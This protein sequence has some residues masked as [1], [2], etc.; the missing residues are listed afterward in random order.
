MNKIISI[1]PLSPMQKG[2]LFETLYRPG[3][4]VNIVQIAIDLP[5]DIVISDLRD[6]CD[7]IIDR[8]AVLRTGFKWGGLDEPSQVVYEK[9]NL[10]YHYEDWRDFDE[11]YQERSF[12][13]Y[14]SEDRLS[15]FDLVK[16][17]LLRVALFRLDDNL[18]KFVWTYHH[19]LMGG[20][21]VLIV[22]KELFDIFEAIGSNQEIILEEPPS[23]R[24]YINWL[25]LQDLSG[26]KKYWQELLSGFQ[27]PTPFGFE[28]QQFQESFST[29]NQDTFT[30]RFSRDKTAELHSFAEQNQLTINTILQGIWAIIL[31]R[32]SGQEDVTFGVVKSNRYSLS[33][34]IQPHS[35]VGLLINTLPM[36]IPVYPNKRL[37]PFFRDIRAQWISLREYEHTP[38]M[39]IQAWSEITAGKPLF[40]SMV[41]FENQ[42]LNVVFRELGGLWSTRVVTWHQKANIPLIFS[43]ILDRGLHLDITYDTKR[44]DDEIICKMLG[45]IEVIFDS[46]LHNPNEK[47]SNL[48]LLTANEK[49]QILA[50]WN[51]TEADFNN[52]KCIHEI[53]EERAGFSPDNMAVVSGNQ[54]VTYRELNERANQIAQFLHRIGVGP[55]VIVGVCLDRSIEFISTILGI[56]KAGGAYLPIDPE[57][58]S[59]RIEFLLTDSAAPILITQ[60]NIIQDLP[61]YVGQ[62]IYLDHQ[63]IGTSLENDF[64][65]TIALSPGNLAYVIY[66][67]GS[68]GKPKGVQVTHLALV[69]HVLAIQHEFDRGSGDRIFQM[70]SFGFDFATGEIFQALGSGGTLVLRN[71]DSLSTVTEFLE[72]LQSFEITF[73]ALPTSVLHWLIDGTIQENLTLPSSIKTIFFGGEKVNPDKIKS[74]HHNFG[75]DVE[76]AN[77]YGP[78]EAAIVATNYFIPNDFQSENGRSEIPIGKPLSNCS[79]YILDDSQ[80]LL[81]VGVVGEIYISGSGLA[82]SY[83]NLP[84]LTAEKFIPNPYAE[85]PGSRMYRTG[86]MAKL[87]DNGN[88][89]FVG[90]LDQQVKYRGHR[91]ELGEIERVLQNHA[92]IRKAA[93][94]VTRRESGVEDLSA[95]IVAKQGIIKDIGTI[96]GYLKRH[97]PIYMVPTK[98][99]FLD[100]LPLSTNDKLDRPL[101]KSMVPERLE[102]PNSYS[103][104]VTFTEKIITKIWERLLGADQIGVD[105]NFF[106]LGGHSLIAAQI[107][108]ETKN[109]FTVEIDLK[110]LFEYPT[111]RGFAAQVEGLTQKDSMPI[112]P[113]NGSDRIPLSFAQQRLWFLD[114]YEDAFAA[115]NVPV[116]FRIMG[117]L[118]QGALEKSLTEIINRHEALRTTFYVKD[119]QPV[120][121]ISPEF[122]FNLSII[123]LQNLNDAKKEVEARRIIEQDAQKPFDLSESVLRSHLIRM[124]EEDSI[125]ALNIHHIATDGWSQNIIFKELTAL[126]KGFTEGYEPQLPD[127]LSQ[128]ADYSIWQREWL[129]GEILKEQL[130]YWRDQLE[131]V[132]PINLPTDKPYPTTQ[133]FSGAFVEFEISGELTTIIKRIC[134]ENGVTLF[135]GLLA[136]FNVFLSRYSGQLD[137]CIGTPVANRNQAWIENLV[138][139]F[140]NMLVIRTDL[141][142]NPT[143]IQL[144]KRVFETTL[145]AYTYQDIPFERLVSEFA[146]ER[147]KGRHPFFQ[148]IFVMENDTGQKLQFEGAQ[149]EP[150]RIDLRSAK[151]DLGLILN[152][153][154]DSIGGMLNYNTDLFERSTI[155]QMVDH[156]LVLL[157]G[158][159]TNPDQ[160]ISEISILSESERRRI[161][162]E[163]NSTQFDYPHEKSTYELFEEQVNK[164]PLRDAVIFKDQCMSYQELNNLANIMAI[165][166]IGKGVKPDT[167][168]GISM[169]RSHEMMI[170]LLGILK[171]GGVYLPIDPNNPIDR[172][173]FM[174]N[175]SGASILLT[176][177]SLESN[178]QNLN[179]EIIAVDAVIGQSSQKN[180]PNPS[181]TIHPENLAYIIYTSG[182]TGEPKGVAIRHASLTNNLLF[183]ISNT[184]PD[185]DL[186]IPSLINLTFDASIKHLFTPLLKGGVVWLIP[187]EV[188]ANPQFLCNLLKGKQKVVINCVPSYWGSVL[189][190]LENDQT[191]ISPGVIVKIIIGAEKFEHQLIDRTYSLFPEIEIWNMYGPTETTMAASSSKLI[192]DSEIT[193]GKPIGN[194]QVYILDQKMNPLPQNIPGILYVGGIGLARGYINTP[195]L[196][197]E[198][199]VPNPFD[200]KSGSRLYNTGDLVNWKPDGN[201][202][203]IGRVDQQVKIR[204]YRIEVEEIEVLLNQLSNVKRAVVNPYFDSIS[205]NILIA[206][207]VGKTHEKPTVSSLREYIQK[208]LPVYMVPSFFVFIEKLPINQIGKIDRLAL[209]K[210]DKLRSE[211]SG[212]YLGPRNH[213]EIAISR[214]WCE[215]LELDQIG[216]LDNFFE[217]GGH[218]LLAAQVTY[219]IQDEFQLDINVK[220]IFD[221]PTIAGLAAQLKG[222]MRMKTIPIKSRNPGD[223][224]P[225]SFAQQRLW[226]L[227]QYEP[228]L[229]AYN[230]PNAFWIKGQLDVEAIEKSLAEIIN[231]HE[232]LRTQFEI[233]IDQPVQ[234]VVPAKKVPF[235]QIDLQQLAIDDRRKEARRLV[236]EDALKPFDLGVGVIRNTLIQ[237]GI[238]EYILI[239]NIHHIASDGWSQAII[240]REISSLYDGFTKGEVPKLPDLQ[241]QYA[242]YSVWQREWLK[243]DILE[244]QLN[245]WRNQLDGASVLNLPIDQP[246]LPSPTYNGAAIDFEISG[247]QTEKL[248]EFSRENRVTLFMTML[249]MF[250]VFL[251]RYSGQL[252]ISVGT[253]IANRHHHWI[254][255][256]VGFFINMLVIRTDLLGN[257]SFEELIHRVRETTLDAYTYQDL[258]FEKLVSELNLDRDISRHPLF[259]VIFSLDQ[260][261]SAQLDLDGLQVDPYGKEIKSAKYEL[262]LH[263][264]GKDGGLKGIFDYNTDLFDEPTIQSMADHFLVV[265][266]NIIKNPEQP[267]SLLPIMRE[268]E[269]E[270]IVIGWNDTR[271]EFPENKCIHEL[272]EDQ[273]IKTPE[274]NAVIFGNQT[275]NYKDLNRSANQVARYLRKK[276]VGPDV[277]VGICMEKSL[278]LIISLLGILKAGGAYVP[279]DPS[280]PIERLNLIIN[281]S[282]I[283]KIITQKHL[284]QKYKNLKVD[285]IYKDSRKYN[286]DEERIENPNVVVMPENL[287]YI[288]YTS[289]STG[290]PKGVAIQHRSLVDNLTWINSKVYE[291]GGILIPTLTN[292]AFDVF[293]EELF[294]P[295][296]KGDAVWLVSDEIRSNPYEIC[297]LINSKPQVGISTVPSY[298]SQVLDIIVAGQVEIRKG[299]LTH[300]FTGAEVVRKELIDRTF[301]LFPDIKIWNLYGPTETTVNAT[302]T[303]IKMDSHITIGKP[304]ANTQVFILDQ[305]MQP[306]PVGVPGILYIGGEGLARGYLNSPSLTAESFL[307]NPFGGKEGSRLY[308]SGDLAKWNSDGL[309]VFLGRQDQQVKIRGLR[310]ELGE[311]ESVINQIP[312]IKNAVVDVIGGF[313]ASKKLVAYIVP[314]EENIPTNKEL[315]EEI[316]SYLPEYMVPSFFAFIDA[317]PLTSSGKIDRKA[318]PN[319][320]L[321]DTEPEKPFSAPRT[322]MEEII[323]G[324]WEKVLDIDKVGVDEN[325]FELGGHSLLAAQVVNHIRRVFEVD[326]LIKTLFEAPTINELGERIA[327]LSDPEIPHISPASRGDSLPL[328]FAQQRLW[329]LDQYEHELSAYNIPSGYR[330]KGHLDEKSLEMSLIEIIRRHE[331][332]RTTFKTIGDKPVQ[333]I[334]PNLSLPMTM[335]DLRQF[336]NKEKEAEIHRLVEADTHQA[337]DLSQNVMRILLFKLDFEDHIL[338]INIHHIASDGWSQGILIREL[339]TLYNAF[340]NGTRPTLPEMRFQYADYSIWQRGWLQGK[341][342]EKQRNYWRD[343]LSG[344]IVLDLPTDQPHPPAQS[345]EGASVNFNIGQEQSEKLKEISRQ[346]RVTLFMTLLSAFNILLA[347]FSGQ[348]D[349]CIGTPTANRNHL[350]IENMIGFFVNM[351]VIRT[352]LTGTIS[353]EELLNQIR[354][355]TLEAY[356]HQDIPFEK[357]VR[358]LD[359]ERDISRTPLF[360][361]I[362]SL[363]NEPE[364]PFDLDGLD[365]DRFH[366]DLKSAKFEM[367]LFLKVSN[368]GLT[369]AMNYNTDLFE[370]ST[371][372]RMID[373]FLVIIDGIVANPQQPVKDLPILRDTE[374]KRIVRNWNNTR[375]EYPREKCVHEIFEEQARG[376][377]DNIA[378]ENNNEKL[379]YRELNYRANQLANYLRDLGV[380]PEVMVGICME[381]SFNLVIGL[382][383]ILKAGSAYVPIDPEYPQKRT[384]LMLEETKA[385]VLVSD[386]RNKEENYQ[387]KGKTVYLAD[388]WDEISQIEVKNPV[389]EMKAENLAYVIFTSGSI[390]SPK[391]NLITHRGVVRLVKNPNYAKLTSNDVILQFANIA[392]DASTFEIW[393]ALLNG[394]I[395]VMPPPER[396]SLGEIGRIIQKHQVTTLWLTAGLFH[397]FVDT[398]L[399]KIKGVRQ[400]I[401]GG[402][403]ISVEHTNKAVKVLEHTQIINGYGP[404]ENTT[405][406]CCNSIQKDDVFEKT[407]P[408][409][410]PVSNTTVYILDKSLN[411]VPIGVAGELYAGGDGLSRG[412]LGDPKLTA[413]KFIPNPFN[414]T[415]GDRLY[416]TGDIVRYLEDGNIEF[417]GRQDHQV[418]VRG[419]RIELGEIEAVLNRLPCVKDVI[420]TAIKDPSG[421]KSLIAYIVPDNE[422]T[423]T[424]AIL[425]EQIRNH[426]PEYMMPKYFEFIEEFQLTPAGKIDR[427]RL[428]DPKTQ[429]NLQREAYIAPRTQMEIVLAGILQDVLDLDK[430]GVTDDFFDLGGHS[431]SATQVVARIED[432]FQVE[433]SLKKFFENPTIEGLSKII[434]SMKEVDQLFEE[435]KKSQDLER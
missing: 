424:I 197:A 163:W 92:D 398:T 202:E 399:E 274:K 206:Y 219:Q 131:G 175:D 180:I 190:F 363:D 276:G 159:V 139:F 78:T 51:N 109:E 84:G 26:A 52:G 418:K 79:V 19:I 296:L 164:T 245:Y 298:W 199:F 192:R 335:I 170:G 117:E 352:D 53:F 319:L 28:N 283:T 178:F 18:F 260:S 423:V 242:D 406:T 249:A 75:S 15:G 422:Q 356:S 81:P 124:K 201:L 7:Q 137:I 30:V 57:D 89:E 288:I 402:D 239:N 59:E 309:I 143:F 351:L 116:A 420:V 332:L 106:E 414:D 101:L 37:V 121:E 1:Y 326:I 391:G 36:R 91:V 345:Y 282:K 136:V 42:P 205:G 145:D 16:P 61:H 404:T 66:T 83:L 151:S 125:L 396:L 150:F 160:S 14:L 211:S 154:K 171:A 20:R 405:F 316:K 410:K 353:F 186:L 44:F 389:I 58:P 373:H 306:L 156:F 236:E 270:R 224:I 191:K 45:H 46:I 25:G 87:L 358:E 38:L 34:E 112:T 90:R 148:V 161:L 264:E 65:Q 305:N 210:P 32:Y 265:V 390:G 208:S 279:L 400:L 138:G 435:I 286:I 216:V 263:L 429:I 340:V 215:V 261:P 329:F 182:S 221:Y 314:G 107:N 324:I 209:P 359:L 153:T 86:D 23:Y 357:L 225:L 17:P 246:Y 130:N 367:G 333:V 289:G 408:I 195:A 275:L 379:T 132:G 322:Q 235:I 252:D 13:N 231:R 343:H 416:R 181:V 392:F 238:D 94:I 361:V 397:Q 234:V 303:I 331:V 336:T 407:V 64:T 409:G 259:Q 104:P 135:M 308:N 196:T 4:G 254:E 98:Y 421:G 432:N 425:H 342:L 328:S 301:S 63:E 142:G 247:E 237:L 157:N 334:N 11:R 133:T 257:P 395:L 430:V 387:F 241:N 173:K 327:E 73:I 103:E 290:K 213:R 126:Y 31:C 120:Q 187:E 294:A 55:E 40:E 281:D 203:F 56:L 12:E 388:D 194:T 96:R 110:L 68:T 419:F 2:M 200:K 24:N 177:Q 374:L 119:N 155:Q 428:P 146:T 412:Y 413:E 253:P 434:E 228:E 48:D 417:I 375:T 172:S 302:G 162:I 341:V 307:P 287:V 427:Q 167:V 232:A 108:F 360:Q 240:F 189:D 212:E 368:Q 248:R 318:L 330:I 277:P 21:A 69:N 49:H 204:G 355:T 346:K 77:G 220:L 426:L 271:T 218:S 344:I 311:I 300:L 33:D 365:V 183:A 258:P 123:D 168:V 230:M 377:P 226:F 386:A 376:K 371:I 74:F 149:V 62:I 6:A 184:L 165:Y 255:D 382:L 8:H 169:V 122:A 144:L 129:K 310:I 268:Q 82:R 366:I 166:L 47:I 267:V 140:I 60:E 102:S 67:S 381:R 179:A 362:F 262:G 401:A 222:L 272:F 348:E 347:R 385:K 50:E 369:G 354:E 312:W 250:N 280:N 251:S 293:V 273:V 317:L 415:Y 297:Q 431:L 35:M 152:E 223:L 9:S 304:V 54:Q 320:D 372:T 233:H 364:K 39:D 269:F 292:F 295:L 85:L 291:N 229:A 207:I 88:I 278:D 188:N 313:S 256:I 29:N 315:R 113:I 141:S 299:I 41:S 433:L 394:G 22:L 97:L 193:I 3:S 127:L 115:Y 27:A 266:D 350:W 176:Q 321:I 71:E 403:V 338:I 378:I 380:G 80:N 134:R 214:I 158:I 370:R 99:C 93:A 5:E 411:P 217:I 147:E 383:G 339:R 10:P 393:G 243:G 111:I 384:E 325:F 43:G 70:A 323:A 72:T 227:D 76:M 174:I 128:Y 114:Q 337:F 100:D 244:G 105:D 349:I 118:N 285:L 198:K 185:P 284:I 95:F